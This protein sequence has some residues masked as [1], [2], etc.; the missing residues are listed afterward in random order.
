MPAPVAHRMGRARVPDT[1]R[2][3]PSYRSRL[4]TTWSWCDPRTTAT[5]REPSRE[6]RKRRTSSP[7][8]PRTGTTWGRPRE[9]VEDDGSTGAPVLDLPEPVGEVPGRTSAARSPVRTWVGCAPLRTGPTSR[10]SGVV[11]ATWSSSRLTAK[12]P[13]PWSRSS[14][15]GHRPGSGGWPAR[16]P[17]GRG[18]RRRA[19]CWRW[20]PTGRTWCPELSTRN[21]DEPEASVTWRPAMFTLK[22]LTVGSCRSVQASWLSINRVVRRPS[23]P[24]SGPLS[25]TSAEPSR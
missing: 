6:T 17:A 12:A 22:V 8:T 19:G 9:T 3:L 24:G 14:R 20:G 15:T 5:R 16:R 18:A 1:A 21:V 2:P 25:V 4:T 7:L 13:I 23:G 11:A 10:E